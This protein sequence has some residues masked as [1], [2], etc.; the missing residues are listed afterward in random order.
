MENARRDR[1]DEA[2]ERPAHD[3]RLE[4]VVDRIREDARRD[5]KRYLRESEVPAGGE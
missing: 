3:E 5:A 4:Q 2:R 1:R